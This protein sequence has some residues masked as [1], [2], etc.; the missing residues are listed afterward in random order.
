MLDLEQVKWTDVANCWVARVIINQRE[1]N[2]VAHENKIQSVTRSTVWSWVDEL[3]EWLRRKVRE[4]EHCKVGPIVSRDC[5]TW[6]YVFYPVIGWSL[7]C[8]AW[9]LC[10]RFLSCVYNS[11]VRK[12][13]LYHQP[14]C[15]GH[16]ITR[17]VCL[18]RCSPPRDHSDVI[19]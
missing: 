16:S 8:L 14:M 9:W 3:T 11:I 2:D 19:L 13:S 7:Q 1:Q 18:T 6:Q 12:V 17:C 15:S 10:N 4:R 5:V